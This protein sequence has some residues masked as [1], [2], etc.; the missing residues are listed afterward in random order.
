MDHSDFTIY[1]FLENFI[2]PK[3]VNE[4]REYVLSYLL[5]V[6]QTS[7]CPEV[8][9]RRHNEYRRYVPRLRFISHR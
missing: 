9:T 6:L 5:Y 3:R 8:S 1:S 2:G 7:S 4:I